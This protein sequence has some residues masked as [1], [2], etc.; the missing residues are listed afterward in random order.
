MSKWSLEFFVAPGTDEQWH[1]SWVES[2]INWWDE[3]GVSRNN[4]ELY[5]VPENELAHYSKATVD[6]MYKF[7]HGLRR[8]GRYRQSN[9]L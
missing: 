9:R 2:R 1:E 8:T 6:I 3:Q 4:L 7:P 5:H